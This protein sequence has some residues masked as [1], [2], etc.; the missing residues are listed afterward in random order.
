[1]VTKNLF[2]KSKA[3][4]LFVFLAVLAGFFSMIDRSQAS[5]VITGTVYVDYNMNGVNNTSGVSP[6]IAIDSGSAGI[7]VTAYD[8]SGTSRGTATSASNGTYTLNATGTGPYRIEFTNIPSGFYPS[9]IGLNNATTIRNIPNGNS[10][11]IDFGI[12]NPTEYCQNNPDIITNVFAVG[13]GPFSA[14]AKFP[15]NYSEELDGRL[16]SIDPTNWTTAP[17]RTAL[18][19]PVGIGT[20]NE[21]GATFGV[22]YDN[23]TQRFYAASF[24]KRGARFGSLSNESTGAIYY[25]GNTSSP[26]PTSNMYVDLNAVFG[27]GTAGANT[28]IAASTPDWTIDTAS[29]P[30][31]G[32]RGLGGLKISA[33][34]TLLYTVNLADRRLYVIPTSGTLNSTTIQRFAI[35][36]SGLATSSGTCNAADVRPFGVGKDRT[37]QIYVGAVCSAESETS[38]AKLHAFVW[39]FAGSAFTLVANNNLTFTRTASTTDNATWQRWANITNVIN[40]PAPMLADIEFDGNDMLVGLR[41]RYGDQVVVPDFYRGYGDTMRACANG[42]TFNFESNGTC[43]TVTSTVPTG[44]NANSGNGGREFYFDQNGDNREEGILGGL[45]QIPG[46]NHHLASMY[47][48]VTFNSAGTRVNNY[49]TAGVQRY[50]NRTGGQIGAY[51]VYLDADLGNF[52][53]AGGVGDT[54]AICNVAPLQIGNRVWND[55]DADGVQDSNENGIANVSMQLW[56]DTNNDSSVDTQIGSTLTDSA[57]N[58][59][60]GGDANAN[61]STYACGTSTLNATSQVSASSDDVYQNTNGSMDNL[62]RTS[63]RIGGVVGASGVRFTGL[64]IPQG[65]TI[66]SAYIQFTSDNST[67]NNSG[68]PTVIIRGE[69]SNNAPTFTTTSNDITN[70]TVTTASASWAIPT[71]GTTSQTGTNQRTPD[72]SAVVQEITNRSGWASG[73]AM[74]FSLISAVNSTRRD[75]E[76]FDGVAGS[77]AQLVVQYSV[78]NNCSYTILPNTRHE[79]RIT[80]ANFNTG[81]A[82]NTFSPTIVNAD[83]TANGTSRDSNGLSA[84]INQIIAPVLTGS[85]GQN[86][87]TVDFGFKTGQF[88]SIGNRVWFDTNNNGIINSGEVG[89]DG[90]SICLLADANAD[91]IPDS[92]SSP[93]QTVTTDSSGYYRFDSLSA[94][95][96]IV[97]VAPSNFASGGRLAGYRNILGINT[98]PMDSSG[99]SVNAE[100]GVDTVGAMNSALTQGIISNTITLTGSSAPMAEPDVPVAGLFT[101]QGSLDNRADMTIDVG[102]YRNCLTGTVWNDTG[103]G[104]SNNGILNA[105]ETGIPNV[106]VKL[107]DSTGTEVPVG[108]DGIY[109]TA[110]D[111]LSGLWTNASG[112]YSFC[113]LPSGQYRLVLS[114]GGTSSTPTSLT[115]DNNIDNDDNGFPG[116]GPFSG[117]IISNLVTLTAGNAGALSNNTVTNST[118]STSDPTVDFG[119]ILAPTYIKLDEM[120]ARSGGDGTEVVWSTGEESDN[121]GFNVYR[122]VAGRREMVNGSL[123]AGGALKTSASL[124]ITGDKYVWKDEKPE[125]G[126]VYYLEDIDMKGNATMHGPI[127]PTMK[128]TASGLVKNAVLLSDLSRTERDSG[129]E[130]EYAGSEKTQESGSVRETNAERQRMI[131]GQKG[132]RIAV[133]HDGWYRVTAA[134][135]GVIGFNPG[136]NR[137]SWQ[138]YANGEEVPMVVNED[139]SIEFFGRGNDTLST[140]KTMYYLI[141]GRGI[142]RRVATVDGGSSDIAGAARSFEATTVREDRQI[143]VSALRNGEAKNFF[144]A[145]IQTAGA[146]TQELTVRNPAAEGAVKLRVKLQGLT[147]GDHLVGLRLNGLDLGTVSYSGEENRVFEYDL[148]RNY[149]TEGINQVQLQ[150]TGAGNDVSLVDSIALTYQRRYVVSEGSLRFELEAGKGG[151]I[152]GFGQNDVRVFEIRSGR[153]EQELSVV[154]EDIDGMPG[155]SLSPAGY[156][157]EMLVIDESRIET[158]ARV[159]RNDPSSWSSSRNRTDLVIITPESL[160]QNAEQLAEMKRA[161]N[162]ATEVVLTEDIYDEFWYG[163]HSPEAIREFLRTAASE[164]AAEPEIRDLVRDSSFDPRNY[165]GQVDHDLVPTKL[166]DTAFQETGSDAWLA[167]LNDDGIEDISLGR[168][169]AVKRKKPDLMISKIVEI[170]SADERGR[171]QTCWWRIAGLKTTTMCWRRNFRETAQVTRIERTSL[172]DA[173]MHDEIV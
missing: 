39:R 66:T 151:R 17:S 80:A 160:R 149:I 166:I 121:L 69:A 13:S 45:T 141:E 40:R 76:S 82:L 107:F 24:L 16:N 167:D 90:L 135:L 171:Y 145:V 65:A 114:G 106:R 19:N 15:Y 137:G 59:I 155:I 110:D 87:H 14:F 36:T 148:P 23:R 117:R 68:A 136:T 75:A 56:A 18:L 154:I 138:L 124:A 146:T 67:S 172:T 77:A 73:N 169:P 127:R 128:F 51:D 170:R 101:G 58:Y 105:G 26:N 70:R 78:Q 94:G 111:G 20:I 115:P 6:N 156:D 131:A 79:V 113:G 10:S 95:S 55:A 88:Y 31:I 46:Y 152:N 4:K 61:L 143:Y 108:Y 89:I 118:G 38:D 104:V 83:L 120:E 161:G 1:M 168:L 109:G 37:G 5:G 28:H 53:K 153:V 142:G 134:E 42:S 3:L 33:D 62:N 98:T 12:I 21:I 44:G 150:S 126:A 97:C 163:E 116:S 22:A 100:N 74:V 50:N 25:L 144:G 158:A 133:D 52:G 165:R 63:L 8:S 96:Y 157:R 57:G 27:A 132:A 54:E 86:D 32:K 122:E 60:F 139:G 48:P 2:S 164:L 112:G 64:S 9:E 92:P 129:G 123:I 30:E 159:E 162:I 81:Q 147:T 72:L 173:E 130:R 47:D 41:D 43:G 71:W 99:A 35:P 103:A 84:G 102:F 49:Y 119:F 93:L 34:G 85:N 125:A 140:N 29:V 11:N 91:G 7:V